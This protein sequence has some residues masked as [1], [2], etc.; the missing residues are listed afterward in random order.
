MK[1]LFFAIFTLAL[2]TV[3][4]SCSDN[5]EPQKAAS[6]ASTSIADCQEAFVTALNADYALPAEGG[7]IDI[8]FK[9]NVDFIAE[10]SGGEMFANIISYGRDR[11]RCFVQ[12]EARPNPKAD[13]TT[14]L[15]LK[16]DDGQLFST[17]LSQQSCVQSLSV[18]QSFCNFGD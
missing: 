13:R 11:N 15:T 5:D 18:S 6:S 10:L 9:A 14:T 16:L 12:I 2:L 7:I 17:V 8:F 1:R 3:T 4:P